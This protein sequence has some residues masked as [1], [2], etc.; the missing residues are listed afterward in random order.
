[1]LKSIQRATRCS[2]QGNANWSIG[3]HIWH[4][5]RT[6]TTKAA[7]P[8]P[9]QSLRLDGQYDSSDE[10]SLRRVSGFWQSSEANLRP[11][12]LDEP[13]G[14]EQKADDEESIFE[15]ATPSARLLSALQRAGFS[16]LIP[17]VPQNK[18]DLSFFDARKLKALPSST[19]PGGVYLRR[20]VARPVE[21]NVKR[22]VDVL[23]K[24]VT[25]L[26]V[27][28][29]L[30]REVQD[31]EYDEALS[32]VYSQE[33]LSLLQRRGYNPEDLV[34]WAWIITSR[35]TDQAVR[36][37]SAVSEAVLQDD[38]KPVPFFLF[39]LILR[40][41]S[42]S[43]ASLKLV[44][45]CVWTR[46]PVG[47]VDQQFL[48]PHDDIPEQAAIILVI[49]L[50]RHARKVWP[51][52][53]SEIVSL[54]VRLMDDN[55]NGELT[56]APE[57]SRKLCHFYNRILSLVSLPTSL[58]PFRHV[59][60]QQQAQFQILRKMIAAKPSLPI[61]REGFRA[62]ISVQV[63]HK[64]TEAERQWARFK[65][66]SWPPW[67][68]DQSGIDADRELVG[69]RSRAMDVLERMQD[70][71]Y[72]P[73]GWEKQAQI[74]A[75]WDTDRS[76]TIQRRQWLR[77]SSVIPAAQAFNAS[78]SRDPTRDDE[79]WAARISATR[80]IKEAWACF[81]SLEKA[82]PDFG[83]RPWHA[84]FESLVNVLQDVPEGPV[85]PG[86]GK[87]TYPEPTSPHDFLYV[88][89]EPP[90]VD[91]LFDRMLARDIK[92][93]GHLLALLLD[94]APTISHGLRYMSYSRL[95]EVVKDVLPN[96]EKY[97]SDYIRELLSKMPDAIIAA[98]VR[99]LARFPR[100]KDVVFRRP[101]S[102][103]T[104]ISGFPVSHSNRVK[105]LSYAI[106]LVRISK[107]RHV[108]TWSAL[109]LG[110]HQQ[111]QISTLPGAHYHTA[112]QTWSSLTWVLDMMK[113]ADIV[114]D[115]SC[116]Q[117][118]CPT[119]EEILL[120]SPR[121]DAILESRSPDE[122]VPQATGMIKQLFR[123][124]VVDYPVSRAQIRWLPTGPKASILS[125]PSPANLLVLVRVLGV[126]GDN[127][128]IL[129]LL[130]WMSRFATELAAV[131]RELSN[132]HRT[133]RSVLI[134]MRLFL[135]RSWVD[136]EVQST[137]PTSQSYLEEATNIVERHADWGGWPSDEETR[138]FVQDPRDSRRKWIIRVQELEAARI[139]DRGSKSGKPL[140]SNG[141]GRG[142]SDD[143]VIGWVR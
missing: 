128:S 18:A 9:T 62:L 73:L 94:Q 80:T 71:G 124:I 91:E 132:G 95:S 2:H 23:T 102:A 64:K 131:A 27:P 4:F 65:A 117:E 6:S 143:D 45:N 26:P 115:L 8:E 105:P 97:N 47:E 10:A 123:R 122:I 104:L 7:P 66:L 92:P 36:R 121:F 89:S 52:A 57:R 84:M 55:S 112:Y 40:S 138:D 33:N 125:V 31:D 43:S 142:L 37:L 72:H 38:R 127:Y 12:E 134:M 69:S 42:M 11:E 133:F 32:R 106:D 126:S 90:S 135:E 34:V 14:E 116:F 22:L 24:Y 21:Q 67:K 51:E 82:N 30:E 76:P 88:P 75:G 119:V 120:C 74:F 83:L 56:V 16:A 103:S 48:F 100:S 109:L 19:S 139:A 3:S 113:S 41:P 53:F 141:A 86:D 1:M 50:L 87:E 101:A 118:I 28:V 96:A 17:N 68:E 85:M 108:P 140:T 20:G 5:G 137:A 129:S 60:V 59:A 79:I 130:R 61:T 81:C 29:A 54:M 78:L 93:G 39:L 110:L 70:T 98:Y 111:I 35:S 15:R 49:R 77:R 13:T 58:H 107:T 63:A 25:E 99:L 44:M 46:S 114:A 136:P